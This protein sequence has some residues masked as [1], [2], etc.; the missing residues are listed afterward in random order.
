MKKTIEDNS[1]DGILL[2]DV[3]E[4]EAETAPADDGLETIATVFVS[5]IA[6]FVFTVLSSL[7]I[8]NGAAIVW[9]C[10]LCAGLLFLV[11]RMSPGQAVLVALGYVPFMMIALLFVIASMPTGFHIAI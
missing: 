10:S 9:L 4:P 1:I 3:F 7:L 8:R 5:F 2:E 11:R 6:P